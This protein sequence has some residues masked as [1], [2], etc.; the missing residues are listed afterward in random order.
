MFEPEDYEQLRMRIRD[1]LRADYPLLDQ[2]RE[3]IRPLLSE[4]RPIKP[5]SATAISLVGSD[6]GNNELIFDPFLLHVVRVVD[7][8][9]KQL[10]F[11]VVSPS[12]DPDELSADQFD[13]SGKPKT[14]LGFMMKELGLKQMK[15]S[16]LS[17]MIPTGEFVRTQRERVS[18]SWVQT[19]RDVCEW[20]VLYQLIRQAEFSTDTLIVR[21]GLLRSKIFRG[22]LF[23]KLRQNLEASIDQIY[24]Q[25]RRRV[26]MVG[27]AKKSKVLT[28]Y[29][30]AIT[31]ESL[32]ATG[33][34]RYVRV[35]RDLEAKSYI[36]EEY[37]RG[38]ETEGDEREAPK[39]V[40]GDMYLVR[41]GARSGDPIWAVD[42]LSSQT[43]FAPEIFGYL[44][45]DAV[46]GFPVP[47]YPKC[48]QK[49]HEYAQIAGFDYALLQDVISRGIR[50]L[51]PPQR[52]DAF[53]SMQFKTDVAARR[54]G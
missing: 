11:D 3:E 52:H 38:V 33:D 20:A 12:T 43:R 54:Y 41:F 37:A 35:P 1:R 26:F 21:D 30:L 50:D 28:R 6:G 25:H 16:E 31:L 8:Y 4:V 14:A 39:F 53:D 49:A 15:L 40:A 34:A 2:L 24:R 19:Y 29:H 17:H 9:G 51:V 45:A 5:R 23:I 42:I 18:P 44:L 46:D 32:F 13:T 27:I 7:S 48:L 47:L 36:W 10:C 22:N